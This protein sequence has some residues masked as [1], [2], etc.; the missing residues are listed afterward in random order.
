MWAPELFSLFLSLSLCS[1]ATTQLK[2]FAAAK[3]ISLFSSHSPA[4]PPSSPL[5]L[6]LTHS[7][8]LSNTLSLAS[9]LSLSLSLPS[10]LPALSLFVFEFSSVCSVSCAGIKRQ[11]VLQSC[12]FPLS[13][14]TRDRVRER[15]R[16]KER[17]GE[18]GVDE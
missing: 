1:Q 17:E 4:A 10:S 11:E 5:S 16:A 3:K 14:K 13:Q 2:W 7:H 6:S 18:R 9:S 15:E 12:W 8:S